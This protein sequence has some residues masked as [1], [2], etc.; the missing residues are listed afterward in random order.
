MTFCLKNYMMNLA[1]FNTSSGNLHFD[2][3]KKELKKHTEVVL[4]KMTYGFKNEIGQ[5]VN[6]H[7]SS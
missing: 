6:F 3:L 1:N 4:R 5:L 2:R 7:T